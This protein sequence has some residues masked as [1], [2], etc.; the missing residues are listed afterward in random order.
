MTIIEFMNLT[1]LKTSLSLIASLFIGPLR[2]QVLGLNKVSASFIVNPEFKKL[3]NT[4]LDTI[5]LFELVYDDNGQVAY[6]F[7]T[8]RN[9]IDSETLVPMEGFN[10]RNL[11]PA[12]NKSFWVYSRMKSG[13]YHYYFNLNKEQLKERSEFLNTLSLTTHEFARKSD[14]DPII[15]AYVNGLLSKIS[16]A[17]VDNISPIHLNAIVIE[18]VF[19]NAIAYPDGT[20]LVTTG[21]L[22]I[23]NNELELSAVLAHEVAHVTMEHYFIR[24]EKIADNNYKL[25]FNDMI[26][27]CNELTIQPKHTQQE[28]LQLYKL[29]FNY[30]YLTVNSSI[31]RKNEFEA[32][33]L[34]FDFYKSLYGNS[35]CTIRALQN[36]KK[37]D[38]ISTPYFYDFNPDPNGTHPDIDNRLSHLGVTAEDKNDTLA[39]SYAMWT[40]STMRRCALSAF[41][42]SSQ[43]LN[44]YA[45]AIEIQR[46]IYNYSNRIEDLSLLIEMLVRS[47]G[48]KTEIESL[49]SKFDKYKTQPISKYYIARTSAIAQV[50]IGDYSSATGHLRS[51]KNM[52]DNALPTEFMSYPFITT[53]QNEKNWVNEYL[54]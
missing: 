30:S 25:V 16:P 20:I 9:T 3:Y 32:D 7:K 33:R 43:N 40:V 21:L 12:D 8:K 45:I 35:N 39:S 47:N 5:Q 10:Y 27:R 4:T 48:E 6:A 53:I 18:N 54:R 46:R 28:L 23:M 42:D 50:F 22:S 14:L 41:L 38:A 1:L 51:Y 29:L 26:K 31:K 13:L 52:L 44:S 2:S 24:R 49:I 34:S 11:R 19:P 15:N 36:L 37:F 17:K